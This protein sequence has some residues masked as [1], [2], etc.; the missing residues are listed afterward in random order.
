MSSLVPTPMITSPASKTVSGEG[1]VW[2]VPPL[3]AT[4]TIEA[5]VC[6]LTM[7]IVDRFP[8]DLAADRHFDLL[9]AQVRAHQYGLRR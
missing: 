6:D 4:A 8:D 9:E 3:L 5:P 1:R 7:Q 2:Y